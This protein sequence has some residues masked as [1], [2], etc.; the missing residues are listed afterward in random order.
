MSIFLLSNNHDWLLLNKDC[1]DMLSGNRVSTDLVI[2]FKN[3]SIFWTLFIF[4]N[5]ELGNLGIQGLKDKI[6]QIK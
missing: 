4:I 6:N 3:E 1:A 2:N 5:A